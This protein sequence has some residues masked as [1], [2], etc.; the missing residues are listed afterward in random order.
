MARSPRAAKTS[1]FAAL[2]SPRKATGPAMSPVVTL[3]SDMRSTVMY[4]CAQSTPCLS[5]RAATGV[6]VEEGAGEEDEDEEEDEEEDEGADGTARDAADGVDEPRASERGIP[7]AVAYQC[8]RSSWKP[9]L[10]R[11]TAL[12]R[13]LTTGSW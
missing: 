1:S 3:P 4:C 11:E 10:A 7:S 2:R 6:A 5:R 8:C 13:C 9:G 12:H